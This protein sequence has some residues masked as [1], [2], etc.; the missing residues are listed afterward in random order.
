VITESWIDGRLVENEDFH[1]KEN[2]H[3]TVYKF[4]LPWYAST[5]NEN[6]EVF[7]P[8]EDRLGEDLYCNYNEFME[9]LRLATMKEF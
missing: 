2:S 4:Y 7:F 1:I 8:L 5:I 9:E 3:T 6:H